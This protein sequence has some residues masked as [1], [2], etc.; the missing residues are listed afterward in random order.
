M[1][2]RGIGFVFI[3][4]NLQQMTSEALVEKIQM[5]IH[6]IM[7]YLKCLNKVPCKVRVPQHNQ[8]EIMS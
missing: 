5:F 6:G 1:R 2:S 3:I 8:I 4:E 7:G